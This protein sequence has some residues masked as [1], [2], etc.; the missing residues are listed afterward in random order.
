MSASADIAVVISP[1]THLAHVSNSHGSAHRAVSG[2]LSDPAA[3]RRA[4]LRGV[5]SCCLSATGIG[6]LGHPVPAQEFSLPHGRPT[7]QIRTG[8]GF[9]RSTCTRPGRGGCRLDPGV[10]VSSR[11]AKCLRSPPAASQRPTLHPGTASIHPGLI[12]TRRFGGSLAFTRPAFPLPTALGWIEVASASSLSFAPHRYRRR[13]SERGRAIEH[14]PGL[15]HQ[16]HRRPPTVK[17]QRD[18]PV[19]GQ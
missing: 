16:R 18:V 15:R 4:A 17:G 11:P 12:L 5:V 3:R 19:G 9:P 2:Q 13:T 1:K 10:A 8:A 7:G 14:L 6:F